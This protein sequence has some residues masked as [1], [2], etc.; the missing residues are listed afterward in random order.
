MS[1]GIIFQELHVAG[2]DIIQFIPFVCAFYA[3][4]FPLFY[5]HYNREGDVIII[6]SAMGTR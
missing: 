5:S 4:K 6:P 3:F 1:K 2:G